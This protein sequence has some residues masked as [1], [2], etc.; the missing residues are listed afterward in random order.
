[1]VYKNL[2]DI[3]GCVTFYYEYKESW[4]IPPQKK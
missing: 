1:M 3:Q 4:T 2:D